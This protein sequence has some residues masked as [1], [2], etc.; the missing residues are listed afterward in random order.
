MTLSRL[1]LSVADARQHGLVLGSWRAFDTRGICASVAR[2]RA[3]STSTATPRGWSAG[4]RRGTRASPVTSSRTPRGG[5]ARQ[6]K[7]PLSAGL[8]VDP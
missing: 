2:A 7:K 8:E 6:N 3:A 1:R 5:D 4:A